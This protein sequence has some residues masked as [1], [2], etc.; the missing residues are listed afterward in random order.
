MLFSANV[1]SLF[2]RV[3]ILGLALA[4]TACQ[5]TATSAPPESVSTAAAPTLPTTAGP[6][7]TP[8]PTATPMATATATPPPLPAAVQLETAPGLDGV[9]DLGMTQVRI[10]RLLRGPDAQLQLPADRLGRAPEGYGWVYV[11]F[12]FDS[13]CTAADNLFKA[14]GLYTHEMFACT[15]NTSAAFEDTAGR[16]Y[17]VDASLDAN[18][19]VLMEGS[20]V[21]ITLD[22]TRVLGF[23]ALLPDSAE[24]WRVSLDRFYFDPGLYDP[25]QGNDYEARRN[26]IFVLGGQDLPSSLPAPEELNKVGWD[27]DHLAQ[28]GDTLVTPGWTVRVVSIQEGEA[29]VSAAAALG[30][31]PQ[32][33]YTM[34]YMMT[35]EMTCQGTVFDYQDLPHFTGIGEDPHTPVGFHD[36]TPAGQAVVDQSYFPGAHFMLYL[37]GHPRP[38]NHPVQI[39]MSYE[40]RTTWVRVERF[41]SATAPVQP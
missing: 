32:R 5:A 27:S 6:T 26:V 35:L 33:A 21:S 14:T 20:M 18:D 16:A 36:W 17:P 28:V 12:A 39:R 37:T 13:A 41:L 4:L 8:A 3:V 24:L 38:G 7:E 10:T 34:D 15:L 29:A 19:Q 23:A 1:P 31:V 11:Q 25:M 22:E 40:N 30:L 2:R 9:A